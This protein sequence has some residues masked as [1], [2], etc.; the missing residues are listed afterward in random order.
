[1][2]ATSGVEVTRF[3]IPLPQ[4]KDILEVAR[5][6]I[7]NVKDSDTRIHVLAA[8]RAVQIH[9]LEAIR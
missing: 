1:M 4:G 8:P 7:R 2:C 3:P 9:L 6:V 5:S